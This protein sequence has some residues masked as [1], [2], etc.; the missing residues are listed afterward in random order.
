MSDP[1]KWTIVNDEFHKQGERL[2][3]VDSRAVRYGD[4]CFETVRSYQGKFLHLDAH[5]ERLAGGLR[6]LSIQPPFK[7][8]E[9]QLKEKIRTLLFKNDLSNKEAIARI[10]VW[11]EGERGFRFS[12][13]AATSYCITV[14]PLP[15]ISASITLATVSTRRIPSEALEPRFKLSNSINY[16]R[17]ATEAAEQRV[18]DA[19]METINGYISETTIANIFWHNGETVFTPSVQCD[20]LPGVTRRIIIKLLEDEFDIPVVEGEFALEALK[21]AEVAWICN[22]VREVVPVKSIDKHTF[23]LPSP[24]IE[25][26]KEAFESYK[27]RNL[28]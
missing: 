18:D 4:G 15:N 1:P 2:L 27:K 12:S 24:F 20:I 9:N 25:D 21:E 28:R 16:I 14:S 22:S 13:E 17:A 19:L 8:D 3:P 23:A 7:L 26:L 6:Y 5:I 11:R 10:Q